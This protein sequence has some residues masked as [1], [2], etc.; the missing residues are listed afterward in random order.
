MSA[1][2]KFSTQEQKILTS[3]TFKEVQDALTNIK[4]LGKGQK[5]KK[6]GVLGY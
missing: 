1:S 2:T 4:K 6:A 3:G 5:T